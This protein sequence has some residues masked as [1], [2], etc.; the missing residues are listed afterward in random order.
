MQ[1]NSQT[2]FKHKIRGKYVDTNQ[3]PNLYLM[4][5]V[6]FVLDLIFLEI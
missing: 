3:I 4:W 2:K 5:C 1:G 6:L